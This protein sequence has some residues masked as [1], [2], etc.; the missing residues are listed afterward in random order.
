MTSHSL[1]AVELI[2]ELTR[3]PGPPGEERAVRECLQGRLEGMGL[4]PE[5]DAKGNLLVILEGDESRSEIV[6]T[7]HMD[8]IALTVTR[9]EDEGRI[10]VVAH[11][12]AYPWK[13]GEGPIDI[14]TRGG[15]MPAILSF[16]SI[17]T[18]SEESVAQQARN[19]PLV[20]DQAYLYTG[21]SACELREAGVRP[22]LRA[23]LSP[24]RRT[25]TH[26]GDR[27][28]SFFLD[29]R[30]DLAV[31]LMALEQI[32]ALR[33]AR[34]PP[35]RFVAT[36]SEEVGGEGAL[37]HLLTRPAP[38][39]VALEIGPRTPEADFPIDASPTI[40]VRDFYAAMD[41]RDGEILEDCCKRLDI[42]PHWQFLSRG[43]SDA[44][45]AASRGFTA[46][47]VTLG[48]PVENSH[49]YEI[50]HVEAPNELLRLLLAYLES[51]R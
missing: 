45:C 14:L 1:H 42:R 27:I 36:V 35:M 50:M 38:I 10:R 41:A 8:E 39:C 22:G 49:G 5:T 17:H 20:W 13:W 19:A 25:L 29:D 31:W 7:A 6:V 23:V 26:L 18:N 48:L 51:A 15:P 47:P 21:L 43:G 9:I 11:G 33:P 3:L 34:R 32:E 44:S 12:G 40:W 28:G 4:H 37:Y 2:E 46:R 30:A 16:G 24:S